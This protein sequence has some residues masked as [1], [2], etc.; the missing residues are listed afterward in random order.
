MPAQDSIDTPSDN[1][2]TL[3]GF[4]PA[5]YMSE[6]E[7]LRAMAAPDGEDLEGVL[8][9]KRKST[10]LSKRNAPLP[11]YRTVLASYKCHVGLLRPKKSVG[12]VDG[13][14]LRITRLS[15]NHLTGAVALH[16]WRLRRTKE[17]NGLLEKRYNEL[18][19]V[20]EVDADDLRDDW[21]QNIEDVPLDQVI[22]LRRIIF[23]NRHFPALSYR[24]TEPLSGST[25]GE[26][27]MNTFPLVCRWKLTT[28]FETAKKRLSNHA[29]EKVLEKL[30][31]EEADPNMGVDEDVLR[32]IWRRQTLARPVAKDEAT[33]DGPRSAQKGETGTVDSPPTTPSHPI[34]LQ[35]L[36]SSLKQKAFRRRSATANFSEPIHAAR[37]S[38]V[39]LTQDDDQEPAR[40]H[41]LIDIS[42]DGTSHTEISLHSTFRNGVQTKLAL[43]REKPATPET[44]SHIVRVETRLC[45]GELKR[46]LAANTPTIKKPRLSASYLTPPESGRRSTPIIFDPESDFRATSSRKPPASGASVQMKQ[47]LRRRPS[48]SCSIS[49]LHP[50]GD[51]APGDATAHPSKTSTAQRQRPQYRFGDSF[52]GAGGVSRGAVMAGLRLKWGFDMDA[53]AIASYHSN[54]DSVAYRAEVADFVKLTLEDKWVDILHLSSPCQTFSPAHTV[55]GKDDDH[56]SAT[57]FSIDSLLKSAQPRI[58]TLENTSGLQERHAAWANS[59]VQQFTILGFSVRWKIL[60][61]SHYGVPQ[62]RRRLFLFASCPGEKLPSFP[63]P[64]HGGDF[65][66]SGAPELAPL[67][68]IHDA[69]SNIPVGCSHHD[70]ELATPRNYPPYDAR[71]RHA[72]CLTTGGGGNY[73]PSGKRD[74]T[75]RELAC[76]QTFPLEHRFGRSGVKKQIGNAVP[77]VVAKAMLEVIRDALWKADGF[78]LSVKLSLPLEFQQD[79]FQELRDE[80]ELVI[81]ARGLGLL[82]MVTNLLHSYDAAGNNLIVVVGA[83]ERENGWIGEAL[84]EQAAISMSPKAR[85]LR[86]IN[87]DL[88]TVGTREAMYA[89]GGIFSITSRILIVDLLSSLL[90]APTITGLVVLHGERAVASSTEAFVIRRYREL[91]KAGFLKAFS[92]NPEPLTAGFA[93]LAGMMQSLFLR[94]VSLW[95]RF[96]VTIAKSLEGRKRAE[97]IELEVPMTESMTQIQNA[98]LECVEAS[99]TELKKANSGLEMDDWTIDS[100]LLKNFDRIIRRQLDPN[101]HRLSWKTR[102]IVSDLTVLQNILRL[103]IT[104]D[105]VSFNRYLDTELAEYRASPGQNRQNQSPWLFLDAADTIFDTARRRVH[106]GTANGKVSADHEDGVR[107]VLEEQPKWAVLAE[108]LEEIERDIYYN[109]AVRGDS[110]GTILVMCSDQQTCHQIREYLQTMHVRVG[111]PAGEGGDD[112]NDEPAASAAFMM[113][114]KLRNYLNWKQGFAKVSESLFAENKKTLDSVTTLR[115][116]PNSYRGKAPPNKR[117]RVRG[118]G[119]IASGVSRTTSGGLSQADEKASHATLLAEV[120]TMDLDAQHKSEIGA[121]PLDDMEDYFKLFDTADLI[122]V[123]PYDGDMDEHVLEEVRPAYVIM[124]EPDA[125]FIKRLEVYRSSHNDRNVRVYILVYSKSVE[126]QRYLSAIRREKDAFTRLIREKA[127]MTVTHTLDGQAVRDPE[128]QFLR[129]VNTRIAGGGRLAATAQPPRVVFDVRETRSPLVSI[130]HG[131]NMIVVPCQL[132]VG[133]YILTPDICVER[134]SISD[135]ISS[136]KNGRLYNQVETMLQY[137]KHTVLL[138]EFD[139]SKSFTLEPLADYS[140]PGPKSETANDVQSKLVL[141]TL[142]FPRLKVVWSSSPYQTALIFSDLKKSALEPDPIRAVQIGLQPVASLGDDATPAG[143]AAPGVAHR[144]DGGGG[145][146]GGGDDDS[147]GGGARGGGTDLGLAQQQRTFNPLPRDML[148]CIPGVSEKVADRIVL[149]C[150]SLFDLAQW[151]ET[152]LCRLVGNEAGRQIHRFFVR[153]LFD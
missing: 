55:D 8:S 99:I 36:P 102:Q 9:T 150:D 78:A 119:A 148:R 13:D 101:W 85:G 7:L 51:I 40:G 97:V 18:C 134:K 82:R 54:F 14:F 1:D 112:S 151:E 117:R 26:E 61:C 81:L 41:V 3:D 121:D 114:R 103:L 69:I 60:D 32:D 133:D 22:A 74:L 144:I 21:Q 2:R 77:P 49:R 98:V 139:Q 147:A 12:L 137:Y 100:A 15:Q 109:P 4:L 106:T 65:E 57:L 118:G 107:P 29:S 89:Q 141:L 132:T 16:G 76:L 153:S 10:V 135:L 50:F 62:T 64:T 131:N 71:F 38:P 37:L 116:S 127:N 90:R 44:P 149:E 28:H 73:H 33:A 140:R 84:A 123:H 25:T 152:R 66:N 128:E 5:D 105:A 27:I 91:N 129:T 56:N 58:V 86:V 63:K 138:I 24:E 23:T 115:G 43:Q 95:P 19:L 122:V 34:S 96:H 136:F 47:W 17:L 20:L 80:D 108:T 120:Q 53:A 104:S 94:K 88:V 87:T 113:R 68:S 35:S 70:V 72:R 75:H 111:A 125:A 31:L 39:D 83:D 45:F 59:V 143:G 52:C 46:T 67:A 79:L 42:D 124:Y 93:P 142:A 110:N 126:E 130:L 6:D 146:G 30:R 145:G 92:D 11:P 48:S